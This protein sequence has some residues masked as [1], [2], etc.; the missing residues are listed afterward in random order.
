M[1]STLW[2][3]EVNSDWLVDQKEILPHI[4]AIDHAGRKSGQFS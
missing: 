4:P 1:S 3:T 2:P